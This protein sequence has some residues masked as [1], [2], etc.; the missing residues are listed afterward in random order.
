M[1]AVLR[2]GAVSPEQLWLRYFA[3]G[4]S[5]GMLE[6]E[7]YLQEA[8]ELPA[9]ERDMLAQAANELLDELAGRLRVPYS[10]QLRDPLPAAGPL[11]ALVR[12]LRETP[13]ALAGEI[14]DAIGDSIAML[15]QGVEAAVYVADYGQTRLVPLPGRRHDGRPP[16]SI[17]GTLAGR[18][19][20]LVETQAAFTDPQPRF[21]VPLVDGVERLGVLDVMLPSASELT[22]PLLREQCE[23]VASLAAHLIT[24]AD[25]HGDAVD[26]ARRGRP[27]GP[28][29]ELLWSLLPPLTAGSQAFTLSGRLEPAEQVGGDAF[30]YSLGPERVQLAVFDAMGHSLGAGLIAATALAA[31]RAARRSGAGLF[32]QAAALDDAIAEHFPDAF[33]TGV[34]AELD[35]GSGTL[36]YIAAGHPEPLLL[37]GG[38]V[39]AGLEGGRRLPFGLGIGEM[40][41]GEAALEPD[42]WVVLYTDGLVEARD[43]GGEFFGLPRLVDLLEREAAAQ[44]PPA[45]TVRRLTASVLRH[46]HGVLQDDATVLAAHWGPP[47]PVPGALADASGWR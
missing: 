15:G 20:Q 14:D 6:V 25:A 39:V 34:L 30:D 5:A 19:F 24:S 27:R 8:L 42:D 47:P 13:R 11:P 9:L 44:Q 35:L 36:R 31:Y 41:V 28:S 12:L 1:K 23:W 29:A 43:A 22:D 3:C 32:G 40:S 33:A 38:H 46:Q 2:R 17:E 45:E 10:R 26:R 4:G 37:R 21:W 7:G 18:A 16:L